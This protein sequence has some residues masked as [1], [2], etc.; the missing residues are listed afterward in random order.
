LNPAFKI[1]LSLCFGLCSVAILAQ[2]TPN[3]N[4]VKEDLSEAEDFYKGEDYK[5]ALFLFLKIQEKGYSNYNLQFKIGV[6]YLNFPGQEKKAIPY[7]E[8]ASKHVTIKY[9]RN[10]LEERNAPPEAL[11]YLG[12]AYRID[13]KLDL[14]LKV[15]DKF[16]K[17]PIIDRYN[18]EIIDNEIQACEI[19]KS[20]QDK[21]IDVTF[22]DIEIHFD[23][24]ISA[25][26]VIISSND[27]V[28]SFLGALKLYKAVFVSYKT[29]EGWSEPINING[30]ILSDGEFYPTAL[31]ANGKELYLIRVVNK[32]MDLYFSELVNGVW[33]PA[34]PLNKNINSEK[35]E[36]Y[37]SISSD[38][39]TLYFSSNRRESKGGFDIFYSKRQSNNDWGPA[40]NL[41][42]NINTKLD[43]IAPAI[44]VDEK[45]LYFCSKGHYNMGGFDIFYTQ[46][47]N[48]KWNEPQN[49]GYPVNNTND[50]IG[51]RLTGNRQKAVMSRVSDSGIYRLTWLEF[52]KMPGQ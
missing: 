30:S 52:T 28:M 5:E 36:N 38:G 22:K 26:N 23:K 24:T 9:K 35:D 50:N 32:N 34:T 27:S 21:P 10:S 33:S 37:A 40:V 44:S 11:F 8:D 25:T 19:A 2:N 29:Q 41:G 17:S 47:L 43:E 1:F 49:I 39:K 20:I 7:L 13:N 6:C 48:E 12:N 3:F 45:S 51:F 42:K 46:R 16:L 4:T 15:Y 31:S 18:L 14:A